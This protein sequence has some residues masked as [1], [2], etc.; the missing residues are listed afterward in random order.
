M[1]LQ[2]GSANSQSFFGDV[3][4]STAPLFALSLTGL[5]LVSG[6]AIDFQR[7][8]AVR[9][10]LQQ[11]TDGAALAVGRA[12]VATNGQMNG[13]LKT[14]GE[15]YVAE[16]TSHVPVG[17]TKI[18]INNNKVSVTAK[19]TVPTSFATMVVK[20]ILVA[21]ESTAKVGG[22]SRPLCVLGLNASAPD[23][24]KVWGS[25][26]LQAP[27]CA[28]QSN[29]W[30]TIGLD[31]G[32]SGM[33]HA[34]FFCASSTGFGGAGFSPTPTTN[35]PVKID[36]YANKYTPTALANIGINIYA[37]CDQPRNL[38][39]S[40]AM[41]FSAASPTTPYLFCGG[42]TINAGA[43]VTFNPG[44]YVINSQFLVSSNATVNA[45]SGVTFML[46][47]GGPGTGLKD[48]YLT[49]Q[50]GANMT[51]KAPTTGPL[52]GMAI[53]QPVVSGYFGGLTPAI[54]NTITGS[55][56]LNITG[57]IYMPQGQLLITGNGQLNTGT[58]YFGMVADFVTLQ[59]NGTLQIGANADP[60]TSGMPAMPTITDP[61][62]APS[63]T[64]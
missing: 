61:D 11:V 31:S 29:S 41:T 57:V 32:G 37:V 1:K 64:N 8:F 60:V 56:A 17:E 36:P 14:M 34:A 26:E 12:A 21:A 28:V 45:P 59:G 53:I 10:A 23:A 52:A 42:L 51:L 25:A 6:V 43:S 24:V 58:S 44:V 47:D 5:L 15:A 27:N 50:G 38:K 22:S 63:L 13:A 20:S 54:T 33:A 3:K 39:I 40:G 18:L 7:A 19:A 16:A 2:H 9:T 46:A 4:G 62:A 49:I 30:N 48:G 55:G 35:C